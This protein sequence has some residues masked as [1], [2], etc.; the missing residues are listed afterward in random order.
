[1]GRGAP[2]RNVISL[3]H[4]LDDKGQK[5]SKSRGNVVNPWEA[6]EKWGADT[7]RFWMY[8][9]NEAG[10][11][12]NFDD[13]TVREASRT[14]SW[15]ENS[16][17]FYELFAAKKGARGKRE[18][19]DRWIEARL[20]ATVGEVTKGFESYDLTLASRSLV[21]FFEDLSQWYVRRIRDR[22]REGNAVAIETLRKMLHT[23]ARLLAPFAPFLAEQVYQRVMTNSDPA[24]VHLASWPRARLWKRDSGLI[25]KMSEVGRICSL[26]LEARQKAGIK[27]RQ[28]LQRLTAETRRLKADFIELIKD[29]VNVKEVVH[30]KFA[31]D[32]TITD[33]LRREG[34]ARDA[35]RAVQ[36]L[37]KQAALMPR[38]RATLVASPED[39]AVYE[40]HWDEIKR[41]ANL[42]R[43][44]RG[45]TT[46]VKP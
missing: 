3:G 19:I 9:V 44:E 6:V 45:D 38:D 18:Q 41:A 30:G 17:K 35:L 36:D 39:F 5:M 14:L 46:H 21:S 4:L 33:A 16:A 1:M 40:R 8:S 31:L 12:K 37:R 20:N 34:E 10:D 29:E 2:Y 25:E 32:V 26:A 42:E 11:Q 22:M 24:S 15:F 23:S 13:K 43:L 27:V 28:P 7:L